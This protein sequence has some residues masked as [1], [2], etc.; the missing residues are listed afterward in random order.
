MSLIEPIMIS[1][2]IFKYNVTYMRN[3]FPMSRDAYLVTE[4]RQS[5][6]VD[7][8]HVTFTRFAAYTPLYLSK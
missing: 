6:G 2:K 3:I 1:D 4:Q 8:Y 7:K 5:Q